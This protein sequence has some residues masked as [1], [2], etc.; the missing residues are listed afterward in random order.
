M[1]SLIKLWKTGFDK[2][3]WKNDKK[4]LING[5]IRSLNMPWIIPKDIFE[6]CFDYYNNSH[7]TQDYELIY[8]FHENATTT[9]ISFKLDKYTFEFNAVVCY[10]V[11]ISEFVAI[12]SLKLLDAEYPFNI[13]LLDNYEFFDDIYVR[14][15]VYLRKPYEC[16]ECGEYFN[17]LNNQQSCTI[18]PL[19][20]NFIPKETTFSFGL[21]IIHYVDPKVL[22]GE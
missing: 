8:F 13:Q 7:V 19:N 2:K 6:L 9:T 17:L 4:M 5:F 14:F 21:S 16:I 3:L 18:I 15:N 22:R 11:K 10:D 12:C 20:T 1:S